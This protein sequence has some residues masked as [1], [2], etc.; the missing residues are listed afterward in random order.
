MERRRRMPAPM[1]RLRSRHR[2]DRRWGR[3]HPA[4]KAPGR[5]PAT[6]APG[7]PGSVLRHGGPPVGIAGRI[8]ANGLGSSEQARTAIGA[9]ADGS[10]ALEIWGRKSQGDLGAQICLQFVCTRIYSRP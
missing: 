8:D 6:E 2:A 4:T 1:R 10:A 5:A 3:L 9:G 7:R